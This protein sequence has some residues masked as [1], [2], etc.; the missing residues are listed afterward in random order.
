MANG[1][2]TSD[3]KQPT[4]DSGSG[5]VSRNC[6]QRNTTASMGG[7]GVA[8]NVA[9]RAKGKETSD[10]DRDNTINRCAMKGVV[11]SF[12]LTISLMVQK[13]PNPGRTDTNNKSRTLKEV[14]LKLGRSARNAW[15]QCHGIVLPEI[16]P[17]SDFYIPIGVVWPQSISVPS[18]QSPVYTMTEYPP[19]VMDEC[20]IALPDQDGVAFHR[21][22]DATW[23]LYWW[24]ICTVPLVES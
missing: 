1:K 22:G 2:E 11:T 17:F 15:K 7:G 16:S 14:E 21:K 4:K 20:A 10:G 23:A 5:V 13:K 9:K 24:I 19:S 12:V 8:M 6:A 18:K 3:T